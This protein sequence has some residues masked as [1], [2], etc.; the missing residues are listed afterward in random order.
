MSKFI[1]FKGLN[2]YASTLAKKAKDIEKVDVVVK[3]NAFRVERHAR[4]FAPVK[5]GVLR[6]SIHTLR[7]KEGVYAV[8]DGVDYGIFQ[9][10]GTAFF[11]GQ[12][13]L[14][15]AM[16]KNRDKFINDLKALIEK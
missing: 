2:S 5:S 11:K 16:K 10:M 13:F 14:T 7:L 8:A 6:S 1:V 9:E 4:L 15:R 12:F 3:R